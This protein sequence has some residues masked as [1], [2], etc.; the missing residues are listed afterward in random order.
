MLTREGRE[1]GVYFHLVICM[2]LFILFCQTGL[3]MKKYDSGKK[4][5]IGTICEVRG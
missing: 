1:K 3:S 4:Q 2:A 5:I